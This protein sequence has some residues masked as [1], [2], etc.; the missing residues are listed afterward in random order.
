VIAIPDMTDTTFEL[1]LQVI[2]SAAFGYSIAWKD[3]EKVP[4]GHRMDRLPFRRMYG[5]LRFP[6]QTFKRALNCVCHNLI[7]R[8]VCSDRIL[9]LVERGREIKTGFEEL[10]VWCHKSSMPFALVTYQLHR[11]IWVR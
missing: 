3:D 2:A 7:A 4:E 8:M 1:A 9:S 10:K 6:F 5:R 11:F